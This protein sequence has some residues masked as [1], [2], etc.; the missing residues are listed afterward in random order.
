MVNNYFLILTF[1]FI[2]IVIIV[3]S[4]LLT[5]I[6]IVSIAFNFIMFYLRKLENDQS[7]NQPIDENLTE[8][9]P[10]IYVNL[11]QPSNNTPSVIPVRKDNLTEDLDKY[12]QRTLKYNNNQIQNILNS[13]YYEPY[14]IDERIIKKSSQNKNKKAIDGQLTKDVNWY[15]YY[16]DGEFNNKEPWWGKS[17]L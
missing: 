1:V 2:I 8:F 4:D 5:A 3:V 10:D 13:S 17:E 14:N 11:M 7:N 6:L 12:D 15:K 9:D 16:F